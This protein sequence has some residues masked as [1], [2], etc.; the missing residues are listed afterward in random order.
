MAFSSDAQAQAQPLVHDPRFRQLGVLCGLPQETKAASRVERAIVKCTG[1][2]PG[3]TRSLIRMMIAEGA[4]HIVSFGICGALAPD[5]PVG[6]II[7]ADEI[8][9]ATGR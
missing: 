7:I 6:S 1:A 5:L 3:Q 4:T 2:K 8:A 9:S